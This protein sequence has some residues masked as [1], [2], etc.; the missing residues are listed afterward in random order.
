MERSVSLNFLLQKAALQPRQ[1]RGERRRNR[2]HR[3]GE[4]AA[5]ALTKLDAIVRRAEAPT[6]PGVRIGRR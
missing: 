4:K 6:A 5:D 1:D 3:G 2:V